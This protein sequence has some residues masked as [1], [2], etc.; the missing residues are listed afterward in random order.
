MFAV[1]L[2]PCLYVYLLT[3][4]CIFFLMFNLKS[5]ETF[6]LRSFYE[7]TCCLS[8][9]ILSPE[10][11][12]LAMFFAQ[13]LSLLYQLTRSTL[14]I[15]HGASHGTWWDNDR[16]CTKLSGNY[17]WIL[18]V[19]HILWDYFMVQRMGFTFWMIMTRGF[20]SIIRFVIQADSSSI[21]FNCAA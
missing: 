19:W 20:H 4:K 13:V 14:C 3:L 6:K 9:R 8:P 15:I 16:W 21:G 18:V 10:P 17:S 11:M 2:S 7:T 1:F 12:A 5:T